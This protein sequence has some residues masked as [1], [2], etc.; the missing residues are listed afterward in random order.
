MMASISKSIPDD[1]IIQVIAISWATMHEEG[2]NGSDPS[3]QQLTH[4]LSL[5][6]SPRSDIRYP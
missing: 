1:D 5:S 3:K 6:L 4:S 2:R